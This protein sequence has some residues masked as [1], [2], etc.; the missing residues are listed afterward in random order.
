[1]AA[2]SF[3]STRRPGRSGSSCGR[4]RP[5][6]SAPITMF[7]RGSSCRST[8]GTTSPAC[9]HA[10][11]FSDGE[12]KDEMFAIRFGSVENCKNFIESVERIAESLGKNEEKESTEATDAA[13]LLDNL[14]VS[15][16]KTEEDAPERA[17]VTADEKKSG[18]ETKSE[19]PSSAA[20]KA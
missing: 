6:R 12:V 4:R 11:D 16:S 10:P 5:S 18:T 17:T 1:M 13:R 20:D 2:S 9:G 14:S 15:T 3:S 7:F 19:E 8:P